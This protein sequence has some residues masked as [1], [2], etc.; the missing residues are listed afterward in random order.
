MPRLVG[1][2]LG[3]EV[4]LQGRN[5]QGAEAVSAGLIDAIVEDG[6]EVA[7]AEAW[8]LSDAAHSIQPWDRKGCL[9][10]S[11][12]EYAAVIERHRQRELTRMLGHEPAPLAIL[13]CVELGLMQ[14]LD[15][16]IR[17][18]M[19]VFARLIQRPEPRNMIRTMFLNKQAW[20]KAK[21]AGEIA[22]ELEHAEQ[23]IRSAVRACVERAPELAR[24]GF[25]GGGDRTV[26]Q[27]RVGDDY[28][29]LAEPT[30]ARE[31]ADL[32]ANCAAITSS[33]TSDQCDQLDYRLAA[34]AVVPAYL[35]GVTGLSVLTANIL[36]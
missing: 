8:L 7:A 18:E 36:R 23:Q 11:H 6:Q 2:E 24:A 28:W 22:P 21:R 20:E 9:S 25:L 30:L 17:S 31:A 33:L 3:L 27:L 1:V 35:G 13:D 26:A 15:G 14:P 19:A 10:P 29:L 34:D 16:A 32:A 5:L 4:L 12:S